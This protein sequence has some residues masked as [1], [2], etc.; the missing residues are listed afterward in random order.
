ML[1]PGARIASQKGSKGDIDL[2][3]AMDALG[4]VDEDDGA[5]SEDD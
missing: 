5:K 2:V 3:G 4:G 1:S